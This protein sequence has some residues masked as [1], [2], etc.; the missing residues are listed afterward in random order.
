MELKKFKDFL[1]RDFLYIVALLLSLLANLIVLGLLNHEIDR[2][3]EHWYNEFDR[4]GCPC[5]KE[6]LNPYISNLTLG[7]SFDLFNLGEVASNK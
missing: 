4:C 2:L 7:R 3:N 5:I 1:K 6:D